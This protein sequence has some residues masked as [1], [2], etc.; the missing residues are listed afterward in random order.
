MRETP[1][2][3]ACGRTAPYSVRQPKTAFGMPQVPLRT[4]IILQFEE[5]MNPF[6]ASLFQVIPLLMGAVC[7]AFGLVV[8]TG[9]TGSP[10]FVAGYVLIFLTAI[11]VALFSTAVTIIRLLTGTSSPAWRLA[12]PLLGYTVS[13][14]AITAGI[15]IFAG[16]S[17]PDEQVAGHVVFG[18]G[19]IACCVSTVAMA[20]TRFLLIPA[21]NRSRPGE[22]PRGAFSRG[23]SRLLMAVP[24]LCALAAF[25]VAAIFFSAGNT[26]AHLTV[27]CVL[28][29]IGFVCLSLI[30]LVASVVRQVCNSYGQRDRRFWPLL[31]IAAAVICVLW[32]L[33]VLLSGPEQSRLAPGF[34]LIGLGIVCCSIL[35]KVLLLALVWR[36]SFP[37]SSRIPLIPVFTALTCLFMGAFLFQLSPAQPGL[38]VPA[39]VI[40]GLGA[41]CF[42]LYSIVSILESG[43]SGKKE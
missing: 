29:G 11:C 22:I 27:G 2:S 8:R 30:C 14:I 33:G 34:V 39:R 10:P 12:M 19:L 15:G 25:G 40:I 5:N 41:V 36:Q 38:Y 18:L 37:L 16:S 3:S 42:T 26:A 6:I 24:V 43:T 21:N 28:G 31:V 20:S 7:L 32:G 9:D 13:A 35:S 17:V 4:L 1:G 23:T